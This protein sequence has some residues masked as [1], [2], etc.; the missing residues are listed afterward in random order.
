M[1]YTSRPS[2][3]TT[4]DRTSS[5]HP[6]TTDVDMPTFPLT[7][8]WTGW[9][10]CCAS[11]GNEWTKLLVPSNAAAAHWYSGHSVTTASLASSQE[12]SMEDSCLS[13]TSSTPSSAI[14]LSAW[15]KDEAWASIFLAWKQMGSFSP[16]QSFHIPL[17]LVLR[18]LEKELATHKARNTKG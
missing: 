18:R 1:A 13:F 3:P 2:V 7:K 14:K 15:I 8:N 11:Q 10:L 5:R 6:L 12:I 17:T 9:T 4:C 16:L